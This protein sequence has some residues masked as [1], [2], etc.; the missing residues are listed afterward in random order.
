MAAALLSVHRG[1]CG[2]PLP[3]PLHE[4]PDLPQA[5]SQCAAGECLLSARMLAAQPAGTPELAIHVRSRD[6]I[7]GRATLEVVIVAET[8]G[9][10]TTGCE[11]GREDENERTRGREKE[12]ERGS[13]GAKKGERE[14]ENASGCYRI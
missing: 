9:K 10:G 11:R 8:V 13:E 14:T 2:V 7:V 1:A 6:D 5:K 12:R 3:P 4:S